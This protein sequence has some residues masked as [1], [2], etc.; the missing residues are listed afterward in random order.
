MWVHIFPVRAPVGQ[1]ATHWPQNSQLRSRS[2]GGQ[3]LVRVRGTQS[4]LP[5][6]LNFIA[7]P[8]TLTAHDTFFHVSFEKWI[9]VFFCINPSFADKPVFPHAI[10]IC[11]FLQLAVAPLSDHTVGRM[12][13]QQSFK[14]SLSKLFGYG[15]EVVTSIPSFAKVVQEAIG[16]AEPLTST[17]HSLHPPNGE[18][19]G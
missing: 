8:Y 9:I 7:Y 18:S 11:K 16:F 17:M 10:E 4:L 1:T 13:R 2:K 3:I 12:I 5:D 15:L 6:S 19:S 14:G